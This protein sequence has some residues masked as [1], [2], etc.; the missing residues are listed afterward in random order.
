MAAVCSSLMWDLFPHQG[1]NQGHSGES[2]K[3]LATRPPGNSHAYYY[4]YVYFHDQDL[5]STY[6]KYNLCQQ[7]F[8]IKKYLKCRRW[9]L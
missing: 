3:V 6:K 1:S 2:A 5:S 9:A 4:S 7:Y 8:H